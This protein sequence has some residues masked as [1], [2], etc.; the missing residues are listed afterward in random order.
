M[1]DLAY[2]KGLDA[3]RNRFKTRLTERLN[4][5]RGLVAGNTGAE[6]ADMRRLLHDLAGTAPSLGYPE[7]G[8]L[9]RELEHKLESAV[10]AHRPLNGDEL[11]D[12]A[13]GFAAFENLLTRTISQ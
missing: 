4:R 5:F 9:A 13:P 11:A 10:Q 2:Q 3:A 8:S 6:I 7:I 12:L 1:T